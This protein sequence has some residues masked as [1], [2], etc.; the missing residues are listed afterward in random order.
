VATPSTPPSVLQVQ[1]PT[2]V[3]GDAAPPVAPPARPP[4]CARLK[5]IALT[6]DDG[7]VAHTSAV[8]ALL[9]KEKV[10]ATFFV[11]GVNARKY[12]ALV[13][14][15][16][17]DGNAVGN[18]SWDHPQF[19]HLSEKQI[20]SELARTDNLLK[21]ITGV[22]PTLV[23]PPFGEV[24]PKVRTVARSRGQ[25]LIL[26]NVDPQDWKDHDPK[27]VTKRVLSHARRNAII[28]SH[29]V[30]P[31]TRHAYAGIIRGLK[32]KGFTLVTVPELLAGRAK[33][34]KVYTRG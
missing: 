30:W 26:W 5:C 25:A 11:M 10:H 33:P 13:R 24:D 29:D 3:A 4:D 31:S 15:M 32:A 9:R 14:R 8:L 20:R 12:P 18:H 28:L 2:E 1:R 21:K 17:A 34:G 27:L 16:L 6:M 22:R 23:R 19:W 7:P